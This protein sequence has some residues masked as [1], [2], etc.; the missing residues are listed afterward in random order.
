[1]M[2]VEKALFMTKFYKVLLNGDSCH[3][4]SFSWGLPSESSPG[5]WHAL[6][7]NEEPILC[8]KGFHVT[9][10]PTSWW[11]E[12]ADCYE[13]ECEGL[14][15]EDPNNHK[16][17]C[18]KIRLLRKLS[19]DDL[20]KLNVFLSGEHKISEGFGISYGNAKVKAFGSSSVR[21]SGS[22]SVKAYGSSSV[23]T[24]DSSSVRAFGSS[25]VE[26]YGSSSVVACD[27]SSVEAYGSSSVV[28]SGSS[29]VTASGRAIVRV[30]YGSP[31][32]TVTEQAV[33]VD[34]TKSNKQNKCPKFTRA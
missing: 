13:V 7:D 14:L 6:P 23:E 27:S 28:A 29:S 22:S 21:A 2:I 25:S 10:Q 30:E 34:Y 26:A 1:M 19:H 20:A 32:V 24:C 3:G 8:Q 12:N 17:V 4:G 18:S 16:A 33:C 31:K 15:P 11:V 9:S 5:E